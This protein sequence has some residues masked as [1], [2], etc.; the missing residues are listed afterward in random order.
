MYV[1]QRQPR[2]AAAGGGGGA[3]DATRLE[4]QVRF[5]FLFVSFYTNVY[6]DYVTACHVAPSTTDTPHINHVATSSPPP[7]PPSHQEPEAA[8]RARDETRL[9]PQVYFCFHLH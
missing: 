6:L 4:P 2:A 1:G 7:P 9:E 3:R 8:A 5:L